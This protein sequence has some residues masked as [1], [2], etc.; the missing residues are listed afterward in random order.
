MGVV[1]T[2]IVTIIGGAIIGA[3]ARLIM[4][5][6]QAMPW[7]LTILVG[8]VAVA[9]G[10]VVAGWIGVAQT[11][12]VDWIRWGITIVIGVILVAIVAAVYPKIRGGS[13]A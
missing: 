13:T 9:I 11:S 7:W 6:R 5:G 8:I 1:W 2:I 10:R 12:G 4:P 3:L